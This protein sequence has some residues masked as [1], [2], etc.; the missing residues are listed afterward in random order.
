MLD[1]CVGWG[2]GGQG[3]R[4]SILQLE[5]EIREVFL[6]VENGE[7]TAIN[8]IREVILE[9]EVKCNMCHAPLQVWVIALL[10]KL[11]IN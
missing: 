11:C 8:E 2:D 6:V 3:V 10:Q 5:M 1:I 9:R 4:E 7:Y